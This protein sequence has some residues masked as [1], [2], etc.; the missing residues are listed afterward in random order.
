MAGDHQLE[1][2][3]AVEGEEAVVEGHQE[4]AAAAEAV[5]VVEEGVEGVEAV[6]EAVVEGHQEAAA[7]AAT[8]DHHPEQR[9][10]PHRP[11]QT[12]GPPTPQSNPP[13]TPDKST[14]PKTPKTPHLEHLAHLEHHPPQARYLGLEGVPVSGRPQPLLES[15][16]GHPPLHIP[17][18]EG[19][20][21]AALDPAAL[22]TEGVLQGPE[23]H[24]ESAETPA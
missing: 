22:D 20:V 17:R 11:T 8:A 16:R 13:A 10:P 1:A 12:T 15:P 9:N 23:A 21:P 2:A 7:A 24:Q 4:E 3:E 6:V 18:R 19:A 14:T 5:E